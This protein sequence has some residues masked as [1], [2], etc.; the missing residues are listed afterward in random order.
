M[1]VIQKLATKMQAHAAAVSHRWPAN[2][3]QLVM[4]NGADGGQLTI[5]ALSRILRKEGVKVG[6]VTANFVEIAGERVE[7][8]DQADVLG[9][10][11]R[12]HALFAQMKRAGCRYALLEVPTQLPA[13]GFAGLQPAMVVMRR[14]G[15]S[16]SAEVENTGKATIWRRL[17]DLSPQFVVLNRDDPSYAPIKG[18]QETATMTFGT[19]EKAECKI[20]AVDVHPKGS[21]VSLVVDHQTELQLA[22]TLTGKTAIYSLVAAAAAAYLLHIP[23]TVIEDGI[24]ALPEQAGTLQ[25][26]PVQRPYQIIIDTNVTPDGMAETLETLK[27]FTK[28]R[29]IVVIGTMLSQ[30]GQWRAL[31]GELIAKYADRIVVTDGE[32]TAEES[33]QTVRHQLLQGVATAGADAKTEEVPDRAEALEKALSI[34]RRGD[35][36]V[37]LASTQRP[38]RQLGLERHAWNDAAKIEELLR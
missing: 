13:H 32:Y 33:A 4:V 24:A 18:M 27:H 15:D 21:A 35:T 19:S 8:S 37:V 7:G 5:L 26:I 10:P 11:F 1:E 29:L 2:R 12:M 3:M 23:I 34:A 28:N 9:D 14:C 16:Y 6:V 17:I 25:I 36:I 30:P 20:T 31:T 22:T 38:Y